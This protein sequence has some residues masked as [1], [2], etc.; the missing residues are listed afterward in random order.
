M[1]KLFRMLKKVGVSILGVCL[2][3]WL[4]GC[5]TEYN[6]ATQQHETLLFGTDKEVAIGNSMSRQIEKNYKFVE[7]VDVNE[8][9]RRILDKIVAVCDREELVYSI[10]VIDE[11]TVNAVS[12]PG[13]YVYLFRGLLDK[14]KTDDQL[15]GVI[16]HEVAHITA[17]HSI[18]KLQSLY[19][20]TL[21][22]LA[23]IT[24]GNNR[25]ARGLDTAF[26]AIFLEYS[27]EDEFQ[28]DKLGIKYSQK[29]GFDPNGM[30]GALKVLKE[31]ENKEPSR[32]H[33]YW[34]THPHLSQRIAQSNQTVKGQLE[35]RDYLN[36]TGERE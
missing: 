28:A 23:T 6:L 26:M 12:L 29:A 4:G 36:L 3:F 14:L 35:F 17:R 9:V 7:D 15:A 20:Y 31:Q 8:R 21:L 16:G 19:G 13:G 24:S 18:K 22:Q 30:T 33:S 32:E 34:R 10:H 11:D 2:T 1:A 5:A 27:Q 25:M